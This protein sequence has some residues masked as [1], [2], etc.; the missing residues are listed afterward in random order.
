VATVP[1]YISVKKHY[2]ASPQT[3]RD[4]FSNFES[5]I[6]DY[7]YQVVVAY[8]FFRL[9]AAYNRTL[10]GGVRKL[11]KADQQLAKSVI[12]K[13]HLTRDGFLDLYANVFGK[14]LPTLTAAKIKFA[15]G[16]RDRVVHGKNIT[17][18]DARKCLT[19]LIVFSCE[20]EQHVQSIASFSPFGTMKGLLGAGKSLD[21]RTTRWLMKGLG[22]SVA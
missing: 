22:F 5:L 1:S 14:A 18:A 20:L 13:Q 2:E 3:V 11:H 6:D 12:D 16:V 10:Y 19:D 9:E 7:E 15:E 17:D 4:Y 21:A 8:C